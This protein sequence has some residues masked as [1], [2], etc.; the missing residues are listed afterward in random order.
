M[1]TNMTTTTA[2]KQENPQRSYLHLVRPERTPEQLLDLEFTEEVGGIP[3]AP[4]QPR[5]RRLYKVADGEL[6]P[7]RIMA[8]VIDDALAVGADAMA[9]F[10]AICGPIQRFIE[11]KARRKLSPKLPR[12]YE[13]KRLP[14]GPEAA[15]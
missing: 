2:H 5:P 11:R 13:Y 6:F 10:L 8:R 4:G 9:L 12:R 7:V 3:T 1:A 15:S 14:S